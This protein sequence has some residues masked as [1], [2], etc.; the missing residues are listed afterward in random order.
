MQE[1]DW[2]SMMTAFGFGENLPAHAALIAA[3]DEP[4]RAYHT[5]EHIEA[6]LLHLERVKLE[7]DRPH[8]VRLALWFHDAVYKIFS[9]TNEKDSAVWAVKFL[10]ENGA[11]DDVVA[12]IET[13][14]L[15]TEHHANPTTKDEQFMLDI[16]LSILG[17]SANIYDDFEINIRKEYKLVPKLIFRKKRKE[18]LKSFLDMERIYKTDVFL[19]EREEQARENLARAVAG[20]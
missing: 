6:C 17:A 19:A 12:R 2:L 3:Y 1:Q 9:G 18:I 11:A 20:L 13:L 8:E 7:L 5:T 4:H 16:D 15:I 14:I 10:R